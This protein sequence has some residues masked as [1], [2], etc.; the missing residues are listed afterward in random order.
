M[1]TGILRSVEDLRDSAGS[2]S[3]WGRWM[4]RGYDWSR[5]NGRPLQF[6]RTSS[7]CLWHIIFHEQQ[8]L[9][10][11]LLLDAGPGGPRGP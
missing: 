9:L 6:H 8:A 1:M 7:F 10:G 11:V 4:A 2:S 3:P 5:T